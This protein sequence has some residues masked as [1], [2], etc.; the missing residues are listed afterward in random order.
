[1]TT[2]AVRQITC[3]RDENLTGYQMCELRGVLYPV[4]VARWKTQLLEAL[5]SEMLWSVVAIAAKQGLPKTS[6]YL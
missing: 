2:G 4:L 6:T 1:M 5:Q 3:H